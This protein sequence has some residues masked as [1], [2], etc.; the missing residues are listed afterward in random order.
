MQ[1]AQ[2]VE[3]KHLMR[4]C[5]ILASCKLFCETLISG[6]CGLISFKLLADFKI[7]AQNYANTL[8]H[9]YLKT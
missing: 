9:F 3:K 4:N 7:S 1:I 5:A 6:F 8:V 2:G